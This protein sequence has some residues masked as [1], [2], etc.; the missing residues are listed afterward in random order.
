MTYPD[1]T[2]DRIFGYLT[3]LNIEDYLDSDKTLSELREKIAAD[4]VTVIYGTGASLIAPNAR[5]ADLRRY[6]P[7]GNT[8]CG[9]AK[10][11]C[12]ISAYKTAAKIFLYN[13]NVVFLWTGAP[14]TG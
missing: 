8:A 1:V 10:R 14:A 13:T 9:C 6:G 5:P 2:D 11:K 7:L 4:K 12:I 3:R